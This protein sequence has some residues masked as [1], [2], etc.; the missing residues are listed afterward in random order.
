MD[1]VRGFLAD[2]VEQGRHSPRRLPGVA[3]EFSRAQLVGGQTDRNVQR[4]SPS[5]ELTLPTCLP[6]SKGDFFTGPRPRGARM[7]ILLLSEL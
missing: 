3:S 2:Q 5:T 4:K 6:G 1:V 7:V